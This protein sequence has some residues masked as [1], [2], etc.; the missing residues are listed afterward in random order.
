MTPYAQKAGH[1]PPDEEVEK[2]LSHAKSVL[3]SLEGVSSCHE[4]AAAFVDRTGK[5]KV[6]RGYF[7]PCFEHSWVDMGTYLL[8]IYPVGGC[9]PHLIAKLAAR[10]Y[11]GEKFEILHP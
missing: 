1:I 10:A 5:G 8:D 4:A 2:I 11:Q 9:R 3:K 7:Y 6:V